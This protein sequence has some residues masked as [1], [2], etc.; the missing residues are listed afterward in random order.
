MN[1]KLYCSYF[2]LYYVIIETILPVN[3]SKHF[4]HSTVHSLNNVLGYK[5]KNSLIT[6]FVLSQKK[7]YIF[8]IITHNIF[9]NINK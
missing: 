4:Y 7:I 1:I 3:I 2:Y 6:L 5:K 9:R 8:K